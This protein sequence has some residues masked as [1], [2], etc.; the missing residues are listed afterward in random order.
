MLNYLFHLGR[1]PQLA[2]AELQTVIGRTKVGKLELIIQNNLAKLE[3]NRRIEADK[4]I[5]LLGGTVKISEVLGFYKKNQIM[6]VL[7]KDLKNHSTGSSV[8]FGIS[9]LQNPDSN[10]IDQL[11]KQLKVKLSKL[12]I[13][14]RYLLP[15]NKQELSSAQVKKASLIE[16]YLIWD[17]GQ[18]II[19]KTLSVQSFSYFAYRDYSR[20]FIDPHAGMLPPKVARIMLNLA[21]PKPPTEFSRVIDP[22]CGTGT[23]AMEAMVLGINTENFDHD[24][25]KCRGTKK[26]LEW[27]A[28]IIRASSSWNVSQADATHLDE[29]ITLPADA[30]VTEP[31]LGPTNLAGKN[32]ENIIKGLD[33]LYLGCLK[34][35]RKIIKLGARIVM[36]LPQYNLNK[37]NI[38]AKKIIDMRENLGYTLEA[39]PFD[40]DRN[41]TIV[42]RKIIV[43][44]KI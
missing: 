2:Y 37:L 16:Y 7:V 5:N 36:V 32:L 20:P 28:K 18:V 21:F 33:K 29:S 3:V 41:H 43:F 44:K 14:S 19:S 12:K 9:Y 25:D 24:I 38:F 15:K 40:Y 11:V 17:K 42:K 27:L 30:I 31:Y 13:S 23:I 35:W 10:D 1:K 4:L 22:F 8:N 26:N 34:N 39:G 6:D